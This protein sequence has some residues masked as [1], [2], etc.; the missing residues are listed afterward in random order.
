MPLVHQHPDRLP[1]TDQGYSSSLQSSNV[2]LD[3]LDQHSAGDSVLRT[4]RQLTPI[5]Q[6]PGIG[7]TVIPK[8]ERLIQ[9]VREFGVFRRASTST[10]A[11]VTNSHLSS[12]TVGNA[13]GQAKMIR[14]LE[15]HIE[16]EEYEPEPTPETHQPTRNASIPAVPKTKRSSSM[17]KELKAQD[18]P[19]GHNGGSD[20]DSDS[21]P[22]VIRYR[23]PGSKSQRCSQGAQR[24]PRMLRELEGHNESPERD[25]DS[26]HKERRHK[27]PL[28][29]P[30]GSSK[31]KERR[32]K[33]PLS[34]PKGSS[35]RSAPRPQLL[36]EIED[37]NKSPE[38]EDR[39]GLAMARELEDGLRHKPLTRGVR[40]D[41][42]HVAKNETPKPRKSLNVKKLMRDE[43]KGAGRGTK[44]FQTEGNSDLSRYKKQR[45]D[46]MSLFLGDEE[47]DGKE[48]L[49][50]F[51]KTHDGGHSQS[52]PTR[53]LSP[54]QIGKVAGSSERN[55]ESSAELAWSTWDSRKG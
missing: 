53:Q 20:S 5:Q 23:T 52:T 32:H 43:F 39:H 6:N 15:P 12:P 13:M 50:D 9:K 29:K 35:Q 21:D 36:R 31:H 51:S 40:K 26:K 11:Q 17:L 8:F 44:R 48:A 18:K 37:Y 34:K 30:K 49:G 45:K 46:T 55:D 27:R 4:E 3:Q 19:P 16:P 1:D 7:L 33:R 54:R 41:L 47:D 42:L 28:S 2:R 24:T 14:E 25:I 22:I 38:A 10:D